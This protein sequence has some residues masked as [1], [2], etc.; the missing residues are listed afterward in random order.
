M[1]TF[2]IISIGNQTDLLFS[3]MN[4]GALRVKK[5]DCDFEK[6]IQFM[7]RDMLIECLFLVYSDYIY[8]IALRHATRTRLEKEDLYGYVFLAL[9]ESDCR[10]L[11]AY[12][13]S[14]NASFKT[15]LTTV[16]N[17]LIIDETRKSMRKKNLEATQ[18]DLGDYS[19]E[20]IISTALSP[21]KE[22]LNRIDEDILNRAEK[23]M[24]EAREKLS[25]EDDLILSLRFSDRLTYREINETLN[26][27]NAPYRVKCA[28]STLRKAMDKEGFH[29]L[30][31]E[32][33]EIFY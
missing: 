10:R 1:M 25:P 12:T 11:R 17:N 23:C 18:S 13:G 29:E 9:T 21:E 2:I 6:R 33:Y 14:N 7:D 20:A 32:I 16:I 26:I 8:S 3:F 31:E 27:S 28:I 15:F 19:F 22:L 5:R 30:K 24:M 4:T